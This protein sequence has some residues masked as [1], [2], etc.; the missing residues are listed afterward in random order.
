MKKL[1]LAL[2]AR[3]IES[4]TDNDFNVLCGDIE[5]LFQQEKINV[6][7]RQVLFRLIDRLHK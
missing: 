3:A 7:E 6:E 1:F 4:K 5:M 2:T